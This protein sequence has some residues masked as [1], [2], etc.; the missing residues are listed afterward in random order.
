MVFVCQNTQKPYLM[1]DFIKQF[2][3]LFVDLIYINYSEIILHLFQ[4]TKNLLRFPLN[5]TCFKG[6]CL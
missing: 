2:I 1:I 6:K 3:Y 4:F 5:K